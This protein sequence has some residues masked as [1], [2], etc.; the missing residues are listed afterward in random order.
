MYF[1]CGRSNF[2][3]EI[4]KIFKFFVMISFKCEQGLYFIIFK[5]TMH[6]KKGSVTGISGSLIV[7]LSGVEESNSQV[8]GAQDSSCECKFLNSM[9]ASFGDLI[10][11]ALCNLAFRKLNILC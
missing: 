4:K 10:F 6:M 5:R 1:V 3:K 8:K 2:E 9:Y 7:K 11:I